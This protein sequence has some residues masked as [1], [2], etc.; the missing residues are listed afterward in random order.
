MKLSGSYRFD[1]PRGQL[2][3]ALMDPGTVE[4]CI[5]GVRQFKTIA[6][7][8]YEIELRVGVGAVSGSYR[9]TL[10]ISDK[11]ERESYR[12][13]VEGKGA[14]T[15]ISGTGTMKLVDAGEATDLL[16]EG[17]G[18]VTGMLAR[19]GQRLMSG[20]AKTQID[21]FLDCLGSRAAGSAPSDGAA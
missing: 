15:T 9:G 12:M 20:V 10:A 3:D 19:V 14:R 13:T 17:E 4:S 8:V 2:W 21:R 7:D 1:V 11:R 18:R 16:Y 6:P 5:P